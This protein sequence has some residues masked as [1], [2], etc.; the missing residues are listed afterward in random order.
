MTET[1][2]N[3][4]L[5]G[6]PTDPTELL[7]ARLALVNAAIVYLGECLDKAQAEAHRTE[8]QI[9]ERNAEANALRRALI[10]LSVTQELTDA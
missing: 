2:A 10:T 8:V 1:N 7:K 9:A 6:A 5:A 4:Y 3:P